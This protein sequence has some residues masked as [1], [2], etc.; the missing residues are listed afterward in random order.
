MIVLIKKKIKKIKKTKKK[1][2]KILMG[3]KAACMYTCI[4][5]N[6]QISLSLHYTDKICSL[7][8][9]KDLEICVQLV[10]T[11]FAT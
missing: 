3:K 10:P 7:P 9:G 4:T 2:K 1:K 8:R 6:W 5:K 11:V